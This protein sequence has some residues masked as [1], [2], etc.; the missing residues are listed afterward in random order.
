MTINKWQFDTKKHQSE[1]GNAIKMSETVPDKVI[2]S[3]KW[4]SW[5]FRVFSSVHQV[6]TDRHFIGSRFWTL[7]RS[8]LGS[9]KFS[10]PWSD[11][12]LLSIL[13]QIGPWSL[14][15]GPNRIVRIWSLSGPVGVHGSLYWRTSLGLSGAATVRYA[16]SDLTR[17]LFDWFVQQGSYEFSTES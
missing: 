3:Q 6:I 1:L 7:V 13:V 4:L 12:V 10:R 2:V 8:S 14:L 11:Q 16:A 15:I 5:T 17:C 9:K